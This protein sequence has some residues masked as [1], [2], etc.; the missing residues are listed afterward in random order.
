MRPLLTT[1]MVTLLI[2]QFS[3]SVFVSAAEKLP[4]QESEVIKV[5]EAWQLDSAS[6]VSQSAASKIYKELE[7]ENIEVLATEIRNKPNFIIESYLY[8]VRDRK[9]AAGYKAALLTEK[10][11]ERYPIRAA[12]KTYSW[13]G[14]HAWLSVASEPEGASTDIDGSH[15]GFTFRR[16]VLSPGEH[17]IRIVNQAGGGDWSVCES[18]VQILENKETQIHCP[19]NADSVRK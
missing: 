15:K 12:F 10:D 4:I 14:A 19:R 11:L 3:Y 18:Q 6:K 9:I 2:S 7:K 1:V 17:M 13:L 8:E 5:I 16:F